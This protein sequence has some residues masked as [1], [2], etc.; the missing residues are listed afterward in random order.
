MKNMNLNLAKT[1][2][3]NPS[4]SISWN[5]NYK[6]SY[7]QFHVAQ[8]NLLARPFRKIEGE[9]K[10]YTGFMQTIAEDFTDAAIDFSVIVNSINTGNEKRD[11]HLKSKDFFDV[12][13]FPLMKF[14]SVSFEKER[15][16]VY[17]LEG[18]C[19]IRGIIKRLV[20]DVVYDGT[21]L[22][23]FGNTIAVFKAATTI[24]RHDFGI[25]STMLAEIFIEK[26][27]TIAL[28]LEFIEMD[29]RIW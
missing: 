16:G 17:I 22:D 13:Q 6:N 14:H 29:I 8:R 24:N 23:E 9:F 27:V 15:A 7:V 5:I 12:E 21:K 2:F 11:K 25:K 28:N 3:P 19:T 10:V 4:K 20:F 26:E 18:N 1:I